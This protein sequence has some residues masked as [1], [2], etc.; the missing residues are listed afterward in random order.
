VVSRPIR[1][2]SEVA[3]RMASNHSGERKVIGFST[4]CPLSYLDPPAA[5]PLPVPTLFIHSRPLV[6]PSWVTWPPVQCHQAAV[7]PTFGTQALV[8]K[9]M[10]Q[11]R[12]DWATHQD[13]P[14]P[15]SLGFKV[16]SPGSRK[17]LLWSGLH[18]PNQAQHPVCR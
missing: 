11:G 3:C 2:H 7:S 5:V 18:I 13:Y 9:P 12:P 17:A 15:R 4:L 1:R 6:I 14:R 16:E 10:D 8:S